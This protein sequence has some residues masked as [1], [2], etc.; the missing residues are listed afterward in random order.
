MTQWQSLCSTQHLGFQS[1]S[2]LKKISEKELLPFSSFT[3]AR[4]FSLNVTRGQKARLGAQEAPNG[5]EQT[6]ADREAWRE[7]HRSPRC[8]LGAASFRRA[9]TG[10]AP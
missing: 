1:R 6:K 10:P 9:L 3:W 5:P 4:K 8:G 7:A 2:E